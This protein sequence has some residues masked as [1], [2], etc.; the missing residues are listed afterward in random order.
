M[1]DIFVNEDISKPENRVNL[2]LFHLQMVNNFH[3]WFCNKL[4]IPASS[5]VYPT[6]NLSGDRPDYIVK[7]A[8][9]IIGYVE[10][11]LGNENKSQL[12]QYRNK[13]ENENIKIFSI[14][15][16]SAHNSDLSLE[17]VSAFLKNN[18]DNFANQQII[19]SAKYLIKLIETFSNNTQK[20]S[21]APVSE[22]VLNLPFVKKLL[23]A[24][25]DYQ[26]ESEQRRAVPGKY[27]IDTTGTKGFS[28]RVYSKQST[29]PTKS[30]ALFSI[31]KGESDISFQSDWWYRK[32]LN[33]KNTEDVENWIN[34]IIYD[35]RLPIDKIGEKQKFKISIKSIEKN[36]ELLVKLIIKLL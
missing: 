26:P 17:E 5:I 19:I 23:D 14:S 24:L 32:Y 33:H 29:L 35:L 21:R 18:L 28:F 7:N 16:K 22:E 20:T 9:K 3:R 4:N 11:E 2:A 10:V 27:Y 8:D 30:T 25:K 36:F 13:Y 31:T 12:S 15:G 6:E 1:K 34:S